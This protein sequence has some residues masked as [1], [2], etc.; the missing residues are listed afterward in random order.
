MTMFEVRNPKWKKG[1]TVMVDINRPGTLSEFAVFLL[2]PEQ[3]NPAE[4]SDLHKKYSKEAEI[5]KP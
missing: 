5:L 4:L 3:F 2:I 1:K